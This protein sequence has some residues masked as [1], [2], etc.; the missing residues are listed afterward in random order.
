MKPQIRILTTV[1]VLGS[2]SARAVTTIDPANKY[3][4]GA[5]MG[6]INAEAD[7][8]NGAVVGEFYCSGYLYSANCGWIHIGNGVPQGGQHYGNA[9]FYDYGVNHDGQGNLYGYAY[10]A[11]IGWINFEQTHGQ[12]K[13]DLLTGDLSGY[14]WGANVGWIHLDGLRTLVLD[15]GNDTDADGIP[16]AW[17]FH[18]I[19]FTKIAL[20]VLSAAGD[21]DGD[22]VTDLDE[23]LADTSPIDDG[24]YLAITDFQ[25]LETTNWVTWPV[26]AT[27]LYTLQHTAA[28]SNGMSW[29]VT[30]SPF[31]PPSDTDAEEEVVGVTDTNRFYRVQA[32]PPLTP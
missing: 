28:L 7:G 10:G 24:D 5:N 21:K 16:D 29:V 23:Y 31:I 14:A 9:T 8:A 19:P 30:S 12:P 13:V 17:E 20:T 26:K 2:L 1:L 15:P 27:R 11:N 25:T 6:W 4:Y 3:A 22:G 32:A 18:Y